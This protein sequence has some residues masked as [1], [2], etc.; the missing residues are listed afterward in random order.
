MGRNGKQGSVALPFY[1]LTP[2][3]YPVLFIAMKD[4][5]PKPYARYVDRM[6]NAGYRQVILWMN[7]EQEAVIRRIHDALVDTD[8][9]WPRLRAKNKK[10]KINVDSCDNE[11]RLVVKRKN[12][13]KRTTKE[14]RK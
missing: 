2:T 12:R 10:P 7:P 3:E 6:K 14:L 1:H 9:N 4:N 11:S 13:V 8:E 5:T